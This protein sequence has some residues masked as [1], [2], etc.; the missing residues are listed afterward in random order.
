MKS[1]TDFGHRS[2]LLYFLAL[3]LGK[4][5]LPLHP[6][7]GPLLSGNSPLPQDVSV[8]CVWPHRKRLEQDVGHGGTFVHSRA[9][10]VFPIQSY[11]PHSPG[12]FKKGRK[13][14]QRSYLL[15]LDNSKAF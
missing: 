2:Q 1:S 5:N 6:E 12:P 3:D 11:F 15:D 10:S 7:N 9:G 4:V 8:S 13:D 14:C